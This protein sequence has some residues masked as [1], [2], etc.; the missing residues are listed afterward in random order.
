MNKVDELDREWVE[1]MK[2]AKD[3]GI[4]KEEI[5]VFLQKNGTTNNRSA[6]N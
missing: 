6:A 2:M 1:L 4:S 5:Q 3:L